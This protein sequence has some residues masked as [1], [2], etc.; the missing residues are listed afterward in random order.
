MLWTNSGFILGQ[1][2]CMTQWH[3]FRIWKCRKNCITLQRCLLWTTLSFLFIKISCESCFSISLLFSDLKP[4]L[5]RPD[6]MT[7]YPSGKYWTWEDL[8]S[9]L[10]T[11]TNGVSYRGFQTWMSHPTG[12]FLTFNFLTTSMIVSLCFSCVWYILISMRITCA[13]ILFIL[14]DD[15]VYISLMI[16]HSHC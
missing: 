4:L 11:F 10:W 15:T 7:V 8:F 5:T 13:N 1:C 2:W 16:S 14:S 9:L 12:Q 6:L 3:S